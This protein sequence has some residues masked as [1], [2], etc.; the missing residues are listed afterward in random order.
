VRFP[1]ATTAAT[2]N[3]AA[4]AVADGWSGIDDATLVSS[5]P[6]CCAFCFVA[7][8]VIASAAAGGVCH[9]WSCAC[10]ALFASGIATGT[11]IETKIGTAYDGAAFVALHFPLLKQK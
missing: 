2:K 7:W 5:S 4:A 1:H 11:A 9:A 8:S 10:G 3:V 6:F